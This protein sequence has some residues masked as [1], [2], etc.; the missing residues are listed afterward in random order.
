[1]GQRWALH[2]ATQALQGLDIVGRDADGGVEVE[3][4]GSRAAVWKSADLLLPHPP[5]FGAGPQPERLPAGDRGREEQALG[6]VVPVA[7]L[8]RELALVVQQPPPSQERLDPRPDPV[9][10][11]LHLGGG[12]RG[13]G[14]EHGLV[15]VMDSV[16]HQRMEVEVRVEG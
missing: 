3:E 13:N 10:D 5:R 15:P 2:V 8:S 14:V 9:H 4:P 1:M 6:V 16:E 7:V 12:R 11:R